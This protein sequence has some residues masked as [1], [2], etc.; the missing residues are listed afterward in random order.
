MEVHALDADLARANG[1]TTRTAAAARR[2]KALLPGGE[3]L[4]DARLVAAARHLS[5]ARS[6]PGGGYDFAALVGSG[7]GG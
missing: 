2:A 6:A 1:D 4:R 3:R 7:T 5:G